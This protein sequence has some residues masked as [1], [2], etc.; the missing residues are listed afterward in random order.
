[1]EAD[2]TINTVVELAY[3]DVKAVIT[4]FQVLKMS[5]S[6]KQGKYHYIQRF[7]HQN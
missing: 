2:L 1:M 7:R 5:K 3:T 4:R 6:E